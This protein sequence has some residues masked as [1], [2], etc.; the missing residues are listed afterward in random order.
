MSLHSMN[1]HG[2]V[3]ATVSKQK[4]RTR[5]DGTTY[6]TQDYR[7]TNEDGHTFEI[8]TFSDASGVLKLA[9]E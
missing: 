6:Y 2:I 9:D 3:S 8:V 1:M 5:D 4:E 7:F